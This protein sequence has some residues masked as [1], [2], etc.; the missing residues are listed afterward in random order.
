MKRCPN[1]NES[2]K[3]TYKFCTNCKITFADFKPKEEPFNFSDDKTYKYCTECRNKIEKS[4][5]F[6]VECGKSTSEKKTTNKIDNSV[7][8]V[9][10]G[11]TSIS[12]E[13]S[14]SETVNVISNKAYKLAKETTETA[15]DVGNKFL[16]FLGII[17]FIVLALMIIN[18]LVTGDDFVIKSAFDSNLGGNRSNSAAFIGE[19]TGT[20]IL[21]LI[22]IYFGF[23]KN[24]TIIEWIFWPLIIGLLITT[25]V[26]I[27]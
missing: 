2:I 24:K 27:S 25:V 9:K 10:R 21:P 17:G 4:H 11:F 22:F 26:I 5:K 8:K 15:K 18:P 14:E 12:K 1:C 7:N 13:L 19:I 6:C 3:E 20:I 16:K 23:R